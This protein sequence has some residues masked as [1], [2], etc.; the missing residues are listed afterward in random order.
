[1]R[2]R[3]GGTAWTWAASRTWSALAAQAWLVDCPVSRW[4]IEGSEVRVQGSVNQV[5]EREE[6]D[7]DQVDEVPVE[8]D[9]FYGHEVVGAEVAVRG[10]GAGAGGGEGDA[11]AGDDRD[12]D[13]QAEGPVVVDEEPDVDEEEADAG[14]AGE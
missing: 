6:E 9:D 4:G 10:G 14:E 11:D 5:Q 1:M 13:A 7:P 12:E 3:D 8:A 2:R